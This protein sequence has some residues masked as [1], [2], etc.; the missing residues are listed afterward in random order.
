MRVLILGAS[1]NSGLALTRMALA[2]GHFVSAFVRD[3]NKLA[4]RLGHQA[5]ATNLAVQSG[6][7]SDRG[8]LSQAMQG[9]DVVINAAGNAT[10]D[11]D[12]VPMVRSIVDVAEQTL[13]RD[14]RFWFFGGAAALDVPGMT[15]R[16]AELRFIPNPF[17]LHLQT[18]ARAEASLLDWSMLCPG[19]MTSSP[20]GNP[21]DDL[22]TSQDCWPVSGPGKVELFRSIRILAAFKKRLPEMVIFYEDAAKVILGNLERGSAYAR[23]RVGIALP[24]GTTVTKSIKN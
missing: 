16:A 10:V 5:S 9:Q 18:L 2:Q 21:H 8:S 17:R 20:T 14:G 15:L 23:S 3:P 4:A 6:F 24:V 19:P 7:I 1:G 22:R 13:G 11:A 12:Y